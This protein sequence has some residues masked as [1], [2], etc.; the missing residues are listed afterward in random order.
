[1]N[2]FDRDLCVHMQLLWT[3]SIYLEAVVILP[4]FVVIHYTKQIDNFTSY[5][6]CVRACVCVCVRAC[7][8]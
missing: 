7:V 4:Q 6:M 2:I 5:Y 1:M 8:R 3:F